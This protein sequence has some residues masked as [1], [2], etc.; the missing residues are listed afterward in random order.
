MEDV[1]GFPKMV[2]IPKIIETYIWLVVSTP[3]KNTNLLGLL[4]SMYGKIKP[5][6][7]S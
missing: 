2:V 5:E 3:L 1:V 7:D 6:M 4:F